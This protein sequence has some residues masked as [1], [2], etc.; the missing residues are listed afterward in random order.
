MLPLAANPASQVLTRSMSNQLLYFHAGHGFRS[1]IGCWLAVNF[2]LSV[3]VAE[4]PSIESI[5]SPLIQ[6]GKS[7][8]FHI[9]GSNLQHVRELIFYQPGLSCTSIAGTSEELTVQLTASGDCPT[10]LHAFRVRSDSGFSDLRTFVVTRLPVLRS[11]D[12]RGE[13]P[14]GS[15]IIG[16]LDDGESSRYTISLT[17]GQRLG[18]DLEAMR[19]GIDMLD[20]SVVIRDPHGTVVAQADDSNLYRQDPIASIVAK[21]TG[22]YSIDVIDAGRNAGEYATYVLHV[23]SGP[24]PTA[25]FPLGAQ[26]GT[27]TELTFTGDALG[28]WSTTQILPELESAAQPI[29]RLFA[30]QNGQMSATPLPFRISPLPNVNESGDNDSLTA[31]DR[32]RPLDS[33]VAINGR[34]E[35]PL[36]R[37]CFWLRGMAGQKLEVQ[38]FAQSLGS[39]ADLLL[40]IVDASQ[41]TLACSDDADSLDSRAELVVPKDGIFGVIVEEKREKGGEGFGYRIEVS[42]HAPSAEVFLPRRDRLSQQMQTISIPTGNRVLA[43]MAVRKEDTAGSANIRFPLLPTGVTAHFVG[44]RND[45]AIVPVVFEAEAGA[46]LQG[47]LIPVEVSV[48]LSESTVVGCFRQVTD[49]VHGPADAI[50]AEH[51]ADRLA[52]GTRESYPIR[53]SVLQPQASLAQDGTLELV[54]SV[55]RD[56]NFKGE[57]HL[58]L[59]WLPPWIDAEPGVTLAP[60]QAKA[61][62]H[63]RAWDKAEIAKWPLVVEGSADTSVGKRRSS[64]NSNAQGDTPPPTALYPQAVCSPL[65]ELEVSSPPARGRLTVAATEQGERCFVECALSALPA[66]ESVTDLVATLEGLPNRVESSPIPIAAKSQTISFEVQT[67]PTAPIGQFGGLYCKLSGKLNGESVAYIVA[68]GGILSI[69]TPGNLSRDTD[70]RPLNRLDALRRNNT[71]SSVSIGK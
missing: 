2:L 28:P 21:T 53:V 24:R 13:V 32:V 38:T 48:H 69:Q 33:P 51:N 56:S 68:R 19:L 8:Q 20:A 62:F 4:P 5:K 64:R 55:E 41:Q 63:L 60:D 17:A 12:I 65:I 3:S 61:V 70:G 7:G 6:C 43:L 66:L 22:K 11:E 46:S 59:P 52:L 35:Q 36:D 67:H 30:E 15:S 27:A 34:I 16:R 40:T 1:V 71:S 54:V 9:V 44:P 45:Q 47:H 29:F 25:V 42:P 37:D 58:T 23:S 18:V 14:L 26:P 57:V 50:Y 39:A 10:G 49:L 31:L